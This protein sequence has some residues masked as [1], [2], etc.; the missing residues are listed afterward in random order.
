MKLYCNEDGLEI[1]DIHVNNY[2][3]LYRSICAGCEQLVTEDELTYIEYVCGY[4]YEDMDN[5]LEEGDI[6]SYDGCNTPDNDIMIRVELR[7]D[8]SP[9]QY[10]EFNKKCNYKGECDFQEEE[11]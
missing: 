9:C 6:C 5:E 4:D 11:L 8:C 3:C 10:G 7:K 2:N 1:K